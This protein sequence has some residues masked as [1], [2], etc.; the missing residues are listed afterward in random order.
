MENERKQQAEERRRR[1]LELNKALEENEK[2]RKN[3]KIIQDKQKVEDLQF[4]EEQKKMDIRLEQQREYL[5]NQIKTRFN[6][7]SN[8]Q[9]EEKVKEAEKAQHEED[10]KIIFY[11][12]EK[13][14]IA[15]EKE[16]K[17]KIRRQKEKKEL[18]KYYDM[19]VEEKKKDDEFEKLL[20]G[21]QANLWKRD[22]EKYKDDQQRIK[23]IIRAKNIRNLEQVKEQIKQRQEKE[24]NR[25]GMSD[26]EFAMNRAKLMRAKEALD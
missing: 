3:L 2:N 23:K 25:F 18:K 5:L 8:P 6:N 4:L 11:M 10:K 24:A 16:L 20:D 22:V 9:A 21:V 1:N 17:E 19:Q 13:C 15:D 14:R 7:A 26:A 12:N